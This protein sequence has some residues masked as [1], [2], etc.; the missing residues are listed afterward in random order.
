MADAPKQTLRSAI[1]NI[2]I[3]SF[4]AFFLVFI[5]A[6]MVILWMVHPPAGDGNSLAL[7]AGFVTLFIKMA[8]DSTGY[9]FTSSAG[10]EKKDEV[11]AAVQTKL[12]EK[13]AGP[14]PTPPTP[15][16]PI[17]PWWSRLN[18]AEK[19][20][21]TAAGTTDPRVAAFITASQVGAANADDLAYLVTKNLLTQD[22]ATA[23]AAP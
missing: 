1:V 22:R 9:Q 12:A 21:I 4:L 13:V 17:P 19:T 11:N 14:V 3:K 15:T 8:A 2:N 20:A 23:I 6:F 5:A 10:S 16:T 18:E 7:L